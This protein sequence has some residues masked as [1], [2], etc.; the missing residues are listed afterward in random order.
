[1]DGTVE[2]SGSVPFSEGWRGEGGIETS[3][4][5]WFWKG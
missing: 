2:V 1:L 3:Y 5:F 4:F